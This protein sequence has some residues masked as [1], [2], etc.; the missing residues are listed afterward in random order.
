MFW[1]RARATLP[2]PISLCIH[3]IIYNSS[4]IWGEYD[5]ASIKSLDVAY[6]EIIYWQ[7]NTFQVTLGNAG[8]GFSRHTLKGLHLRHCSVLPILLLQKPFMHPNQR[9][10]VSLARR[11]PIWKKGDIGDLLAEYWSLQFRLPKFSPSRK[12]NGKLPRL[13]AKL[14][15][16][17]KIN[18]AFQLL[19]KQG[20][21][22]VLRVDD[23]VDLGDHVQKSV[24]DILSPNIPMP[25][26]AALSEG[27][28]D[29]PEVHPVIFDQI[30]AATIRRA[31][32]RTKGAADPSG[33]DAHGWR[34]LHTSFKSASHDVCHVLALMAR[35]LCT[36]F[37]HPK[38]ISPFLACRLIALNKS[39]GV[40]PIG[41]CETPRRIIAKAV[42]FVPGGDHKDDAGSKQLCAGKIAGIEA[43]LHAMRSIFSKKDTEAVLW[44]PPTPSTPWT[45]RFPSAMHHLWPTFSLTPIGNLQN[46][47]RM[48]RCCALKKE[49]PRLIPQQC[50][51]MPLQPPPSSTI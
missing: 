36:T 3:S 13:F 46:S 30:N 50:P 8:K 5:S 20:K 18:A 29:P 39:P 25:K 31:A 14:M 17:R 40:R 1:S 11:L 45:G 41:I 38:G 43:A 23:T 47:W 37:V 35:Q 10:T 24:L 26:P 19:S 22:G 33:T 49:P 12:E 44:M 9:N 6:A 34:R 16:Q 7:K 42:L 48:V 21:G 51:Y 28:T 2:T 32:L 27:N 4:F 15:F